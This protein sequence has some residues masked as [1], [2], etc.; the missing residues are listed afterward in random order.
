[1]NIL[2]PEEQSTI[3][4]FLTEPRG[5]LDRFLQYAIYFVPS[6]AFGLYGIWKADFV[7]VALAYAVLLGLVAYL[8]RH[9]GRANPVFR[10]AIR[11]LIENAGIGGATPAPPIT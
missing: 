4:R 8:I 2:T 7:A 6:L 10:S 11:K 1:M 3:S 5:T 9:Q